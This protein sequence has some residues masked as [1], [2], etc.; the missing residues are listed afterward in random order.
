V[1][2]S[3]KYRYEIE[4]PLK[5]EKVIK[6]NESFEITSGRKGYVRFLTGNVKELV[7]RL[8]LEEAKIKIL[9]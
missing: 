4:V 8:E 7:A 3:V 2:V 1:F 9:D 5:Y 6:E